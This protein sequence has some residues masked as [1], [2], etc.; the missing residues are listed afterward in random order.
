ML[1]LVS[2]MFASVMA[3]TTKSQSR[4]NDI[5][6]SIGDLSKLSEWKTILF[7]KVYE[8]LADLPD[9]MTVGELVTEMREVQTIEK[10]GDL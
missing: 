4:V 2:F 6:K 7:Q 3:S 5:Q 1:M 8:T 9:N 10:V